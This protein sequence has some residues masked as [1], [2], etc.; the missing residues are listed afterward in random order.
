VASRSKINAAP[1]QLLEALDQASSEAQIE[2]TNDTWVR[3]VDQ[4]HAFIRSLQS[5]EATDLRNRAEQVQTICRPGSDYFKGYLS[6]FDPNSE[7]LFKSFDRLNNYSELKLKSSEP[8]TL[9]SLREV[10]EGINYFCEI[11]YDFRTELRKFTREEKA[12]P[13]W[14]DQLGALPSD[15]EQWDAA[16]WDT[17]VDLSNKM[18]ELEARKCMIQKSFE[19][20]G[21]AMQRPECFD[22]VRIVWRVKRRFE[23]WQSVV[24]D[25]I[26]S[27]Q[28]S[29]V[30]GC[31]YLQV[32]TSNCELDLR[33]FRM[34]FQ[35]KERLRDVRDVV[36]SFGALS[37]KVA[38]DGR[39]YL[40]RPTTPLVLSGGNAK[41]EKKTIGV[42]RKRGSGEL[43]NSQ[44]L[45]AAAVREWHGYENKSL[46]C[47][48]CTPITQE[49]LAQ[50]CGFSKGKLTKQFFDDWFKQGGN[51]EYKRLCE[52][53]DPI[54][55][56]VAIA[57]LSR[58]GALALLEL[59]TEAI[60]DRKAK[61]P[62]SDS[63]IEELDSR[64]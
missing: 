57:K 46:S 12:K 1:K 50:R 19:R 60:A 29:K 32:L 4:A 58:E 61:R 44:E 31:Y 36:E 48:N 43:T 23:R 15:R 18:A 8:K 64:P 35:L 34:K 2:L 6:C 20:A 9:R 41:G 47:T 40:E 45:M 7:I 49:E 28:G 10:G 37:D 14:S 53:G 55:L 38:D 17:Y 30:D 56:A 27:L 51:G 5:T 11:I 54:A 52:R 59:K 42:G 21:I 39:S 3:L 25:A 22:W 63:H 13:G 62:G 33:L 26:G 24:S 16:N